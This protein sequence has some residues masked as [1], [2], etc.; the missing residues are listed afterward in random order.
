MK[1]IETVKEDINN[2]FK[3]IQETQQNKQKFLNR[4]QINPFPLGNIGKHKQVNELNK[5]VQDLKMEVEK[6]KKIQMVATQETENLG[7]RSGTTDSSITNRIQD[8]RISGVEDTIKGIDIIDKETTWHK[9]LSTQ[10][11]Q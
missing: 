11:I 6:I 5:A 7:K 10:I 2:S 1:I 8:W 9:K 4:K 3:G